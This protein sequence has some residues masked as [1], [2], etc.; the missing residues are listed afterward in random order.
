M[1]I[2]STITLIR[3]WKNLWGIIFSFTFFLLLTLSLPTTSLA[4]TT[5]RVQGI[6]QDQNSEA[7]NGASISVKG[8]NIQVTT[9]FDG[10]FSIQVPE[11]NNTRSEEHTS[12]LQSREN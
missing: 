10:K 11:N 2:K 7:V 6:V 1:M 5:K 9:D 12:E 4:Q 8:T 3:H